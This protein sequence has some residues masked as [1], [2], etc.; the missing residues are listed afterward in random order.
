MRSPK[1][2]LSFLS[3]ILLS[4]FIP[5]DI[6]P[7]SF[8]EATRATNVDDDAARRQRNGFSGGAVKL[9]QRQGIEVQRE[10]AECKYSKAKAARLETQ[11]ARFSYAIPGC[12]FFNIF[13]F[14]FEDQQVVLHNSQPKS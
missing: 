3:T 4:T 11:V 2:G 10:L 5:A 12:T 13:C 14:S 7:F 8:A 1:I 6:S 9:D